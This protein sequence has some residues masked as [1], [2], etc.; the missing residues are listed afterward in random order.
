[1]C[2]FVT[3][4]GALSMMAALSCNLSRAAIV[5]SE[6]LP[7]IGKPV[8]KLN[9]EVSQPPV[10]NARCVISARKKMGMET[11]ARETVRV[12]ISVQPFWF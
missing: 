10:L 8:S 3:G 4:S 12:A 1:M 5:C 11:P 7:P 6:S 2:R 9:A